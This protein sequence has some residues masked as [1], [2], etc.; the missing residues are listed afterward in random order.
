MHA[1]LWTE[2][3]W[4]A[5]GVVSSDA[6]AS[7]AVTQTFLPDGSTVTSS[8]SLEAGT[9]TEAYVWAQTALGGRPGGEGYSMQVLLTG[10]NIPGGETIRAIAAEVLRSMGEGAE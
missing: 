4:G 7:F 2:I 9:K 6:T 1:D 8:L 5:V 3:Q 10:A